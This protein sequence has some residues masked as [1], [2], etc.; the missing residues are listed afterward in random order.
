MW[1]MVF[2]TLPIGFFCRMAISFSLMDFL[3]PRTTSPEVEMAAMKF[4]G[5]MYGKTGCISLNTLHCEMAGN[6]NIQGKKLPPTEDAFHLH[7]LCSMYQLMICRK[8]N[9]PMPNLPHPTGYGYENKANGAGFQT[10]MM[11]QSPGV[12]ELLSDPVGVCKPDACAVKCSCLD[13][14][15]PCTSFSLCM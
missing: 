15:Q 1:I 13:N 4:V 9:V 6:K 12:S 8:A 2:Q 7:L 10:Q 3:V 14:G 5:V 11:S